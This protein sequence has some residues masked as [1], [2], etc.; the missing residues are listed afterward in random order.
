MPYAPARYLSAALAT[1]T[2]ITL[3]ATARANE[4]EIHGSN[5]I[6]AR[7]APALIEGY[8]EAQ[9]GTGIAT[10]P[11]KVDNEQVVTGNLAGRPFEAKVAAHGSG[12]GFSGLKSGESDI[13][14]ASRPAKEKEIALLA[15]MADL[16]DKASEHVIAIDGLA[17]LV[18]SDNPI[19]ALDKKTLAR[20]FAGEITN[21]KMLGGPDH[22]IL[23]MRI[24]APGIPSR[25]WCWAKPFRF[26][27][28]QSAM[29]QTICFLTMSVVTLKASALPVWRQCGRARCWPFPMAT[30]QH[31]YQAN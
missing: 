22:A 21:W 23:G 10:R 31:Y 14:A 30:R 9:G 25:V 19:S 27:Q 8:L 7:L 11:G 5:T 26:H 4:L 6:G 13:A 16:R 24:P 20:I 28:K 15:G 2:L 18:H 17:I 1:V 3:N 29:N 12:T